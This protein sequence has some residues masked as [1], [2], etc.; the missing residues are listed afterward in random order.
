MAATFSFGLAA[1]S[2]DGTAST[3]STTS[4]SSGGDGGGDAGIPCPAGSHRGESG[5][6]EA[7]LT[8]W[9]SGPKL[10]HA[11]DHHVT[12]VAETPAGPF[13][14]VIAGM[15]AA[16][17]PLP[18][19]RAPIAADGT[20]GAFEDV[21]KVPKG[22]IGPGFAQLD[23]SFVL[24]GGLGGDSNSTGATYVGKIGDDGSVTLTPGPDLASSR[25][26]VSIAYAKGYVFALGGLF[27]DVSGGT[28]TQEVLDVVE[29]AA[30]DGTTLSP[31][32]TITK[33]PVKL[34]HHA[35]IVHDGA[36]YIIGGGSDVAARTDI[37]RAT[38]SDGG[39]LGPWETVGQLPE[40]RASPAATVFLER[41]YVISGMTSLTDG[42]VDTVHAGAFDG[43]GKLGP[44]TSLAKL[45]KARAHSH[46]APLYQGHFYSAGGSIHHAPQNDVFIGTF[47]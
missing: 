23:R 16:V 34:T 20:L 4:T 14:Y 17:P 40:G 19:E 22:I 35:T 33:L 45:P 30:F 6:C 18:I 13:L 5:A 29:R 46:Q 43:S 8:G 21:A 39:E 41:L 31:W 36:I 7:E 1:C 24:G 2:G 10:A 25:Y 38:V 37:L 47:Q 3:S 32:E 27:Q 26:H 12:F 28:P 15:G 9:A 42:E 11:R 44:F